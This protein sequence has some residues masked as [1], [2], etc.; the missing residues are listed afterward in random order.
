[1]ASNAQCQFHA[2]EDDDLVT[3]GDNVIFWGM[4]FLRCL[5]DIGEEGKIVMVG[6]GHGPKV[7]LTAGC[8]ESTGVFSAVIFG[9]WAIT[10][11]VDVARS[12]NLEVA[13]PKVSTFVHV[14]DTPRLQG[15][16]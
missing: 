5:L 8:N 14:W 16:M 9:N 15:R 11:P 13:A 2:W 7:F 10:I 1:L 6:Y 12:V 4:F 3:L